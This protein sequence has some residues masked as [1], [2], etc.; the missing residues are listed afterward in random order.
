MNVDICISIINDICEKY[1]IS[2]IKYMNKMDTI[3]LNV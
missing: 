3:D 2:N 1:C